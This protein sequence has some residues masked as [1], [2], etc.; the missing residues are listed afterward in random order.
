MVAVEVGRHLRVWLRDARTPPWFEEPDVPIRAS[1]STR[2]RLKTPHVDT[3][4]QS[5]RKDARLVSGDQ[6]PQLHK[7]ALFLFF[8]RCRLSCARGG[9]EGGR[10][11]ARQH[12]VVRSSTP[13]AALSVLSSLDYSLRYLPEFIFWGGGGGGSAS[14][15]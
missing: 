9:G 3:E 7:F 5:D 8:A 14:D 1:Q 4:T 10:A 2:G 13:A 15:R 12:D 11:S 6:A